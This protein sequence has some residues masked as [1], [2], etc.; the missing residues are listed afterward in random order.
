MANI[1]PNGQWSRKFRTGVE[2]AGLETEGEYGHLCRN[3]GRVAHLSP[4]GHETEHSSRHTVRHFGRRR[5]HPRDQWNGSHLYHHISGTASEIQKHTAMH[6]QRDSLGKFSTSGIRASH[7]LPTLIPIRKNMNRTRS[8][9]KM[10]WS[11][12]TLKITEILSK[13]YPTVKSYVLARC[14][15]AAAKYRLPTTRPLLCTP[16]DRPDHPKECWWLTRMSWAPCWLTRTWAPSTRTTSIWLSYLWLTSSNWLQVRKKN[17]QRNSHLILVRLKQ[18]N[19]FGCIPPPPPYSRMHVSAVRS[20]N[21]LLDS[22][23]NDGQFEQ[24][25]TRQ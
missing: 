16:A 24:N 6:T 2:R 5:S 3:S 7:D 21:R 11:P 8:P 19:L 22:A 12:W 15:V 13:S 20:S 23:D 14:R 25:Q 9:S 18:V 17:K 1:H 4:R 10:R